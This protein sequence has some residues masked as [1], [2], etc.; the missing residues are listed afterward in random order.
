MSLNLQ[1][2]ATGFPRVTMSSGRSGTVTIPYNQR[3]QY[4]TFSAKNPN[5][6]GAPSGYTTSAGEHANGTVTF[7]YVLNNACQRYYASRNIKPMAGDFMFVERNVDQASATHFMLPFQF[8]NMYLREKAMAAHN[9]NSASY[10]KLMDHVN[11]YGQK[12]LL[13]FDVAKS[14]GIAH[15]QSAYAKMLDDGGNDFGYAN[16]LSLY[17]LA[18]TDE[19][20]ALTQLG[21]RSRWNFLGCLIMESQANNDTTGSELRRIRT[22]AVTIVTQKRMEKALNFWGGRRDLINGSRLYFVLSAKEYIMGQTAKTIYQYVPVAD[23]LSSHPYMR[24]MISMDERN[25]IC[26]NHAIY[27]GIIDESTQDSIHE[28]RRMAASGLKDSNA[29]EVRMFSA[30]LPKCRIQIRIH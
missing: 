15:P 13:E 18:L 27:V 21:V 12:F 29:E 7:R 1:G 24:D 16:M 10:K 20:Y 19:L 3:P 5:L 4:T 14:S 28:G 11:K 23:S 8:L 22:G 26:C 30:H 17:N 25:A 6:S 9:K 2:Q